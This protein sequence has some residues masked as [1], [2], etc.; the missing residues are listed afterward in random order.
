MSQA[1]TG[2][3]FWERRE[4]QTSWWERREGE[5]TEEWNAR[6]QHANFMAFDPDD[7]DTVTD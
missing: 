7:P 5:T 3:G 4:G 2:D 6:K 1:S